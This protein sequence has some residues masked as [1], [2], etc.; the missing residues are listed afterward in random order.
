MKGFSTLIQWT[1]KSTHTAS[2]CI[3]KQ[4]NIILQFVYG[5]AWKPQNPTLFNAEM[6]LI[7]TY[8]M[9]HIVTVEHLKKDTY[10]V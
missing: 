4:V 7:V 3:L 1:Y 6:L 9:L 10:F 2:C 5:G 8:E